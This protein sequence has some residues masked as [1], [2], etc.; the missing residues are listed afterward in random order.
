MDI[1]YANALRCAYHPGDAG[2][3]MDMRHVSGS[4]VLFTDLHV[5]G[6]WPRQLLYEISPLE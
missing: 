1:A 5:R 2:S 6:F 4:N 3:D